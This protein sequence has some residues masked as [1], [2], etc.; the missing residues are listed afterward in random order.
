MKN[1]SRKFNKIF[2]RK[3]RLFIQE[4]TSL[5]FFFIR[6]ELFFLFSE[7]VGKIYIGHFVSEI[8]FSQHL[9]QQEIF[10][11]KQASLQ[12]VMTSRF[13]SRMTSSVSEDH[14]GPGWVGG[15]L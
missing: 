8:L 11:K 9:V 4:N 1:Q 5:C 3:I 7:K 15:R 10:L 12:K 2:L 13:A 14:G 6:S